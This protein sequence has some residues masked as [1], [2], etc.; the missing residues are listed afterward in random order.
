MKTDKLKPSKNIE[1][2]RPKPK[3]YPY[4]TMPSG[5]YKG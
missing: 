5:G 4:P 1:D 2:R 3:P